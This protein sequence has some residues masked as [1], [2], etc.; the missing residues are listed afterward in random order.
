MPHAVAKTPNG[1]EPSDTT[2]TIES[3]TVEEIVSHFRGVFTDLLL[4]S[5]MLPQSV[6]ENIALAVTTQLSRRGTGQ[7]LEADTITQTDR[8][9]ILVDDNE[10]RKTS[11][12]RWKDENREDDLIVC[13]V[14]Y[15]YENFQMLPNR[16][17]A[18]G[19]AGGGRWEVSG[20]TEDST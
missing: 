2:S 4:A 12:V 20:P 6:E 19:G 9:L 15:I 18:H 13:T 7:R 5:G 17:H 10:L 11:T 3:A 14:I 1:N 16:G 8:T